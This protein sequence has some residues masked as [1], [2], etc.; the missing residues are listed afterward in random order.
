MALSGAE[1]QKRRRSR[2]AKVNLCQR[3][4]VNKRRRKKPDKP[5]PA[6]CVACAKQIREAVAE[7]RG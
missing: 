7:L 4:G 2:L 3:C 5:A 6:Y 1:R